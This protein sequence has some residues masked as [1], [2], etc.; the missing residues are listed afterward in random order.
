[1]TFG[2]LCS[3]KWEHIV[4]CS[5]ILAYLAHL[6]M[7]RFCDW[8]AKCVKYLA[9]GTFERADENALT[10]SVPNA[11]YA[12]CQTPNTKYLA[13]GTPNTENPLTWAILNAKCFS[14]DE[15]YNFK[16]RTLRIEMLKLFNICLF[17]LLSPM[18][19]LIH[20]LNLSSFPP[21]LLIGHWW[22]QASPPSS[23][24]VP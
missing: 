10:S 13:F 1:M 19:H 7:V 21:I 20:S 8:C 11:K 2:S 3:Q 18:T 22:D 14:M 6:M 17:S 15:R 23:W 9:F 12:K 24:L 5:I 16:Y 4:V